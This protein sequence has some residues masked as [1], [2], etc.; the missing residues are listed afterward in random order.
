MRRHASEAS[1]TGRLVCPSCE[2]GTLT[3]TG[4][5]TARCGR[6][7]FAASHG[8]L[9]TLREIAALP[10]PLGKH[11]CECGHPEMRL[12]PGGVFQCPACGAEVLPN[13]SPE[14][15]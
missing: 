12:L 9:Q 7:G 1:T 4:R 2:V 6:C 14:G 5:F 10:E 3:P 8:V 13:R 11:A 15:R